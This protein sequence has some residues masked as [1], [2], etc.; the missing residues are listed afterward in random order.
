MQI[1]NLTLQ[2]MLTMFLLIAVGVLLRKSNIFPK[3]S[4]VVIS[5]LETFLFI[6]AL[7][8]FNQM[9]QCTVGTLTENAPL[10]LYGVAF[11]LSAIALAYLLS[12]LFV[13]KTD[14]DSRLEN[15]KNVYRYALT[16]GNYGFVGNLIILGV[17]GDAFFFKYTLFT[18]GATI[19]AT[20]WGL[21]VLVPKDQGVSVWT[22]LKKGLLTPPL[23]AFFAGMLIG[24]LNLS[25]FVPDFAV[26]AISY[27]AD[28]QVPAG[29]VLAGVVIGGFRFGG[30]LSNKKVYLATAFRLLLIPALMMLV[31]KLLGADE[32]L[33]VLALITY[34][35]PIGMNTIIYP[36]A[37]GGDSRTG[38]SM[39]MISHALCVATIPL[40]YYLFVVLL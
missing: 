19:A 6:P 36:A 25:R 26:K 28:C 27:A 16:F 23:I 35:T 29:L 33:T 10:I 30:L 20:T 40:M 24:L 17:F 22:N 38:A 18:F 5:R 12:N 15:L 21:F 2:Q 14:G 4:D 39:V 8:L 31:L 34:A 9:T 11:V 32:E 1:F 3:N 37:Y 13:G 7:N